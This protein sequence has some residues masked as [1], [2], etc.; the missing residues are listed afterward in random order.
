M[1]LTHVALTSSGTG[2]ESFKVTVLPSGIIRA[3]LY[4]DPYERAGSYIDVTADKHTVH[5][6]S[7]ALALASGYMPVTRIL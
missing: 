2:R 6:L 5:E 3:R 7:V 1:A 4:E